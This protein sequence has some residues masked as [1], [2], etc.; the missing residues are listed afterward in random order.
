MDMQS[1][2]EILDNEYVIKAIEPTLKYQIGDFNVN[3]SYF[4]AFLIVFLIFGLLM[5]FAR[6]RRMQIGWSFKGAVSMIFIGFILA[7]IIEGFFI[8]GGRTVLT[9][10]LGWENAPKPIGTAID[11]GREQMINVLG[12]SEEVPQSKAFDNY[13]SDDIYEFIKL[14]PEEELHKLQDTMCTR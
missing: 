14:L 4:Q 13:T 1:L 7:L 3:A 11:T 5:S 8:I 9:E 12:V 6:L 2:Y 10:L